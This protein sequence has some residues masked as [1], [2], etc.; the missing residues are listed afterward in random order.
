MTE[1]LKYI[2]S[3]ILHYIVNKA[4]QSAISNKNNDV[5][6][7]LSICTVL[8]IAKLY[9]CIMIDHIYREIV[10]P[11]ISIL[12]TY[13]LRAVIWFLRGFFHIREIILYKVYQILVHIQGLANIIWTLK[14]KDCFFFNMK[15]VL[16]QDFIKR[17]FQPF[18]L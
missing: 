4:Q 1:E 9:R 10:H 3:Y 7:I 11:N 17:N 18:Y 16:L 14:L 2:M 8:N 6:I 5:S 15:S 13:D 12:N